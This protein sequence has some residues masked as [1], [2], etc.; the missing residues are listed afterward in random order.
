M[1]TREKTLAATERPWG[2]E[3]IVEFERRSTS[4]HCLVSTLCKTLWT[5]HKTVCNGMSGL[6]KR[7]NYLSI[8]DSTLTARSLWG[9]TE[10]GDGCVHTDAWPDVTAAAHHFSIRIVTEGKSLSM[11]SCGNITSL[12][13]YM[14]SS[15]VKTWAFAKYDTF[16][17]ICYLVQQGGRVATCELSSLTAVYQRDRCCQCC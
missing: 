7:P 14:V 12:I 13:E 4:S 9:S 10:T 17:R 5:C 2:K 15:S 3:K 1:K 8:T 16:C 6:E 11:S